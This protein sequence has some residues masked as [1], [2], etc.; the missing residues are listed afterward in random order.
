MK[1][2]FALLLLT[3][4]ASCADRSEQGERLLTLVESLQQ[5]AAV[6]L[7]DESRAERYQR[8]GDFLETLEPELSALIQDPSTWRG[9]CAQ[10]SSDVR[11]EWDRLIIFAM[12]GQSLSTFR[13]D[14]GS[15]AA[16]ID[17]RSALLNEV[18]GCDVAPQ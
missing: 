12:G 16:G 18:L 13:R 4:L 5:E 8:I 10:L 3:V 9:D 15:A 2:V 7:P 11:S 17:R 1:H 6:T 14:G